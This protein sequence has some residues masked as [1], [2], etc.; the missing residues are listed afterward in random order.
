MA[1]WQLDTA[2]STATFSVRH[3]MITTVRGSFNIKEGKIEFDPAKPA[4]ASVEAV[5]D[6][7]SVNTGVADRDNHLRSPDFFDA[8]NYPTITFK[9][10][11]VKPTGENTAEIT[12]DLTIRGTTRPV[13]LNAEFL[14]Q[15]KG[16]DGKT[17]A[18][19][20]AST[21]INRE[22]WGLTWNMVLEA[23]GLLVGKEVS[24]A[25]DVEAVAVEAV[26]AE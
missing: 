26:T 17:R 8:A 7:A 9:S 25:L 3:M 10:T 5:L 23:G 20:T 24:I 14:G 12:G 18:G 13:V 2:H 11:S 4:A 16:I 1:T 6:V 19:F 22:D 15:G 21:K